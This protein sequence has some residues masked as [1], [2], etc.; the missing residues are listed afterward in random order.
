M[1]RLGKHSIY[2][3]SSHKRWVYIPIVLIVIISW[4]CMN[5]THINAFLHDVKSS[6]AMAEGNELRNSN[7]SR[8]SNDLRPSS[9]LRDFDFCGFRNLHVKNV[10][11]RGENDTKIS[12]KSMFAFAHAYVRLKI[13]IDGFTRE[14]AKNLKTVRVNIQSYNSTNNSRLYRNFLALSEDVEVNYKENPQIKSL[15]LDALTSYTINLTLKNEG[16][17]DL[18]K[19]TV[20]SVSLRYPSRYRIYSNSKNYDS[21]N[22]ADNVISGNGIGDDGISGNVVADNNKADN[23]SLSISNFDN[24]QSFIRYI[25][26][27]NTRPK[28]SVK[29]E[30]NNSRDMQYFNTRRIAHVTIQDE[31]FALVKSLEPAMPIA[32]NSFNNNKVILTA[33]DFTKEDTSKK[34]HATANYDDGF[35]CVLYGFVDLSGNKSEILKN[36]FIV[37]S[38]S[39]NAG[40]T[41]T[42][43]NEKRDSGSRDSDVDSSNSDAI[44]SDAATDRNRASDVNNDSNNNTRN[45]N[46]S[47]SSSVNVGN[48]KSAKKEATNENLNKSNKARKDYLV[49]K[50]VKTSAKIKRSSNNAANGSS[51]NAANKRVSQK[52]NGKVSQKGSQKVSQKVGGKDSL[53]SAYSRKSDDI[54]KRDSSPKRVEESNASDV[55]NA[56]DASSASKKQEKDED[57]SDKTVQKTKGKS[58][59]K[60]ENDSEVSNTKSNKSVKK[61]KNVSRSVYRLH[62]R[63]KAIL[64]DHNRAMP[65]DM[66]D[67]I[68]LNRSARKSYAKKDSSKRASADSS[69]KSSTKS[70]KSSDNSA[71]HDDSE[72]DSA[73]KDKT[74]DKDSDSDKG[75]DGDKD[76][77]SKSDDDKNSKDSKDKNK[78]DSENQGE[79][80]NEHSNKKLMSED[81][82]FSNNPS[83]NNNAG[84]LI[85]IAVIIVSVSGVCVVGYFVY[86]HDGKLFGN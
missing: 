64:K 84:L 48:S 22:N 6:S 12:N 5:E 1:K 54:N 21:E 60:N 77:G 70:K 51:N 35:W 16:I 26:I 19:I 27:D 83:K 29:Y 47:K 8:N 34:W 66:A 45:S 71:N 37:D 59:E 28:I 58:A 75:D 81:K 23:S 14:F 25:V 78:D 63:W 36:S 62:P 50:S 3:S 15:P 40:I 61:N 43:S 33:S 67:A 41:N 56:S 69:N 44:R 17:Y 74:S 80:S 38:K 85:A 4:M 13:T 7:D 65:H 2:T 55:S 11:F 18:S 24:N 82:S 79:I 20:K 9:D 39:A 73:N 10:D 72:E 42:G 86:R 32:V 31:N 57:S 49:E 52:V 30:D 53:K 68:R 46:D 76:S